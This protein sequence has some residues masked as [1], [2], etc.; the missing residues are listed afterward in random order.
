M[1]KASSQRL[2]LPSTHALRNKS[3]SKRQR[4]QFVWPP[5]LWRVLEQ[6]TGGFLL[7]R[8]HT[9]FMPCMT[10]LRGALKL[11][12]FWSSPLCENSAKTH[13]ENLT[14]WEL[15]P[16]D[17]I[18]WDCFALATG[19]LLR[20]LQSPVHARNWWRQSLHAHTA[21][22]QSTVMARRNKA[23]SDDIN[24]GGGVTQTHTYIHKN[25]TLEHTV[26]SSTWEGAV[27]PAVG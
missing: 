17:E 21:D 5:S 8:V 3:L 20:D 22:S 23:A 26:L 14:L 16:S 9:E 12:A 19:M 10:S 27:I 11:N 2:L 1:Y 15:D 25:H 13:R 6:T 24:H 4:K 7:H 18:W